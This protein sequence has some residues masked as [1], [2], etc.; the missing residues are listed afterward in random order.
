MFWL[1]GF[2]EMRYYGD[3]MAHFEVV[4]CIA[5]P[6]RCEISNLVRPSNLA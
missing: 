1:K 2:P 5:R 3:N 6:A 4:Q